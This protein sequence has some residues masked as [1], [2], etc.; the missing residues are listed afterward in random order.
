MEG[1]SLYKVWASMKGRCVSK[2]R[3]GYSDRGIVVCDEWQEFIPFMEWAMSHGYKKPLQIDRINND[4]NYCPE[5][6]RFVTRKVNQN[7][8]RVNHKIKINNITKNLAAWCEISGLHPTT[9]TR[10]INRGWED[11]YLLIPPMENGDSL[12]ESFRCSICGKFVKSSSATHTLIS[13]DSEFTSE[14]WETICVNCNTTTK[15]EAGS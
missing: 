10:R 4:G 12:I 6:C 3:K 7:N 9:I 11:K 13:P 14:E 15:A 1:T 2:T 5:N 8:R